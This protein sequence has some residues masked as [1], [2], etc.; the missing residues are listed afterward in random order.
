MESTQIILK[1]LVTEKSS[2]EAQAKNRY[3][4]RVH[5]TATKP[6][7][8]HAI[9]SIYKVRVVDV[10]TQNRLGDV[11][12]TRF[13]VHQDADWKRAVVKL[14]AEDKIELF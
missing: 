14:H 5:P 12:R 2:W 4:F 8:K 11:R 9:E 1:P 10:S 6:Q 3:S 7:I 13:G